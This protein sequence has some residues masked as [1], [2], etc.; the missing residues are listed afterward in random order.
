M[1]CAA[2]RVDGVAMLL[3]QGKHDGNSITRDAVAIS[4]QADT[5]RGSSGSE[6]T[7]RIVVDSNI[8]RNA[9]GIAG[10]APLIATS[11][12][13]A[14][15]GRSERVVNENSGPDAGRFFAGGLSALW[16]NSGQS[17]GLSPGQIGDNPCAAC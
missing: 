13:A 12:G 10:G 1:E 7:R 11:W 14:A 6:N 5:V 8:G 15:R 17:W 9:S 3:D 16:T 4:L 2:N